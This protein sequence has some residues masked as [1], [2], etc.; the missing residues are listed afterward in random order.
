[1]NSTE[2]KTLGELH[3]EV[4][5]RLEKA[6]IEEALREAYL[7]LVHSGPHDLAALIA[8]LPD[9]LSPDF[10]LESLETLVRRRCNRE[11]MAYLLGHR[12]F[13]GRDFKVGPGALIPRP[14]TETLVQWVLEEH[15]RAPFS[16]GIDLCCGPGPLGITLAAELDIPF[17][18]VD[19]SPE[20]IDLAHR[21]AKSHGHNGKIQELD[22]LLDDV[23]LAGIDLLVCNPPYIPTD[24]ISTL[25]P[26]VRDHEPLLA[27][28][29][30][31][32]G[33]DF[34]RQLHS[35]LSQAPTTTAITAFFEFGHDQ[36]EDVD[37]L[38]LDG[39][40]RRGWR[41]DLAGAQRVASFSF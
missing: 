15:E 23:N 7:L 8:R 10:D 36:R 24:V 32:S 14:D 9:P 17:D 29:G 3:R 39:W 30:G 1:M 11:P 35:Q 38:P 40:T 41:Q 18:M 6:G 20:A 26:E 25:M 13:F 31:R 2:P 27:L 34:F 21:N 4:G 22:L 19:V 33:L 12:E 28:D 16:R 5:A 37:A